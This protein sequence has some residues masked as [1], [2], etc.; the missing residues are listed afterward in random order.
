MKNQA[1]ERK[2]SRWLICGI[3]VLV[4]ASVSI[5]GIGSNVARGEDA[6]ESRMQFHDVGQHTRQ[7]HAYNR[8]I[9]LTAKQRAVMHEALSS[10]RAP[11]CADRTAATCCCPC[12]MAK[13]W[14][15]LSKHLIAER[16]YGADRVR[17]AVIDWIGFINPDGFSGD[18][19][20][21][22]RCNEPFHKNG[23][24]GMSERK[25]RFN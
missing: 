18:A 19:C 16:D 9:Q 22:G 17:E 6:T 14:W 3:E 21:A 2:R 1:R 4:I 8:S 10:V 11:C 13:T 15:G 5:A 24:G 7:F 23:C 20:Y 25:G 12:N